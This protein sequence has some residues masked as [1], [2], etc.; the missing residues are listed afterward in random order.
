MRFETVAVTRET[1]QRAPPAARDPSSDAAGRQ[2]NKAPPLAPRSAPPLAGPRR[3]GVGGRAGAPAD[4][5]PPRAK[6]ARQARAKEAAEAMVTSPAY[7]ALMTSPS[8]PGIGAQLVA[9]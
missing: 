6:T 2:P 7:Q 5:T 9:T 3:A 4:P 1:K 8:A